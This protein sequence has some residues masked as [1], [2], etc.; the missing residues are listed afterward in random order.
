MFRLFFFFP[1]KLSPNNNNNYYNQW[2]SL[3]LVFHLDTH[4]EIQ[5]SSRCD[6][7]LRCISLY[8]MVNELGIVKLWRCVPKCSKSQDLYS[9][10]CTEA[11]NSVNNHQNYLH[12]VAAATATTTTTAMQECLHERSISQWLYTTCVQKGMAD[13]INFTKP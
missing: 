8:A 5:K 1:K 13:I 9:I 4:E 10:H 2:R 11:F 12:G 6:G 3:P 7:G